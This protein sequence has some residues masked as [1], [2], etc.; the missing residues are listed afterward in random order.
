MTSWKKYIVLF[1][2]NWQNSL[3]YRFPLVVYIFG[4]SL[5]II[6]LLYLWSSIYRDGQRMGTYT[7]PELTTYYILQLI[8]NSVIFSYVSWDIIDNIKDGDFSS[9][10][11]RPVDYYFYWFTI[12]ISGKI[13]EALFV[14]VAA[15]SISIIFQGYLKLPE[16]FLT[17]LYFLISVFLGIVLAFEMDFCIGLITF[18]LTQ[19]RTFKYMLQTMIIFLSGAMLPLDLFP[20]FFQKILNLLPFKYLVFFPIR[21]Y[22]NKIDNPLPYFALLLFWIVLFYGVSRILLIKGIRRYE[23]VGS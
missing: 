11:T 2:I 13:L 21:I 17:F 5:Y 9:F 8:I 20:P 16:H 10:L 6:V 22:L 15:C 19:V 14:T 1:K 4:Y 12:N 23:A 18:W 3:Q 7:L